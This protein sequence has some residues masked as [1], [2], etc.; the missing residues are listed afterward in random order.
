MNDPDVTLKLSQVLQAYLGEQH[1]V[2]IPPD[3]AFIIEAKSKGLLTCYIQWTDEFSSPL[4]MPILWWYK[5]WKESC[6]LY[7]RQKAYSHK[8]RIERFLLEANVKDVAYQLMQP[9]FLMDNSHAQATAFSWVKNR[10]T[11][12]LKAIG[13]NKLK[14]KEEEL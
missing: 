12:K 4:D 11:N 2:T 10:K 1:S 6:E 7:D 5:N 8:Q 9:P 13:I 14:E 3:V